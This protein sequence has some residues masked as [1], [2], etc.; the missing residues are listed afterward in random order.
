[1]FT[2]AASD[3]G[4][5][6]D[7]IEP[8]CV[9]MNLLPATQAHGRVEYPLEW[10]DQLEAKRQERFLRVPLDAGTYWIVPDAFDNDAQGS[11]VLQAASPTPFA[12]A[13]VPSPPRERLEGT[14]ERD[15]AGGNWSKRTWGLN[16]HYK[17]DV[18]QRGT[19]CFTVRAADDSGA[20]QS[21]L[22]GM[23]LLAATEAHGRVEYP[24]A[25][26]QERL[27][28]GKAQEQTIN[29]SLDP[30]TYWIVPDAFDDQAHGS[31]VLEGASPTSTPFALALVPK[32]D[33]LAT[34]TAHG[35]VTE[36]HGHSNDVE[37]CPRV[38]LTITRPCKIHA[39]MQ[40]DE[41]D[42]RVIESLDEASPIAQD[43]R[44]ACMLHLCAG[45]AGSVPDLRYGGQLAKSK[46]LIGDSVSL[47][48]ELPVGCFTLVPRPV[49]HGRG[50]A[51]PLRV[52]VTV[53][54]T[55]LR[56]TVWST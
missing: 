2:V 27:G 9:G 53:E 56:S 45:R 43:D 46:F 17:L 21:H 39:T 34:H 6:S 48:V 35:V 30:G 29:R 36:P 40:C 12:L 37:G 14:W 47:D 11:F 4:F 22:V 38:E 13:L 51:E 44:L 32:S 23:S 54:C 50:R 19:F 16:P 31:F 3:R 33:Y 20:V 5:Y 8:H 10:P 15:T 42:R 55:D 18:H 7:G 25:W 41:H 28:R 24:L 26:P 49:L 52:V 1:L